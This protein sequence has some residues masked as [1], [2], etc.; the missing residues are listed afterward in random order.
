MKQKKALIF[1]DNE[2]SEMMF[3]LTNLLLLPG[4]PKD[5]STIYNQPFF[6]FQTKINLHND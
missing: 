3:Q 1:N 4:L 2:F 5:Q 6:P